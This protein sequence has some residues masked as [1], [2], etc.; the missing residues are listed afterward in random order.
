VTSR[1]DYS[2][3]A[4]RYDRT[5]SASPSTLRPLR[6]ALEGAPGPR[7]LDVGGGTG[8]YALALGEHG[9]EPTVLDAS[10]AMLARAAAKGLPTVRADATALPFADATFDAVALVS[11]LHHVP[12][13]PLALR[14]AAR[15]LRPGG[16]L[17]AVVHTRENVREVGWIGEY[18]PSWHAWLAATHQTEAELLAVLPG[19]RLVPFEIDDLEDASVA[20]LQRRPETLLDTDLGAQSSYFDRLAEEDPAQLEAGLARLRTDLERGRRPDEERAEARR[21]HGDAVVLKWSAPAA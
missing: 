11:M 4:E 9:W 18:L 21:R 7:L 16:R 20:A 15:V 13:W 1:H 19:A 6:A 14:E 2:R 3:L 12:E 10:D 5:R 8:N 17:A